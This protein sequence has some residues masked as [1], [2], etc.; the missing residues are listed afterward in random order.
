[1]SFRSKNDELPRGTKST[2][3]Y[4]GVSG[5]ISY[6]GWFFLSGM[7][8]STHGSFNKAPIFLPVCD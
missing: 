8:Q 5:I 7:F 4:N 3:W 2:A 1:M 6:L